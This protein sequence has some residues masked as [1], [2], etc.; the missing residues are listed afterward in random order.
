MGKIYL[1]IIAFLVTP[2]FSFTNLKSDE[3]C[4]LNQDKIT[5]VAIF[6]GH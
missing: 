3:L 2:L 5:V 4:I 6:D 1:A